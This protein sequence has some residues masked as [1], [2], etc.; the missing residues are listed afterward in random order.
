MASADIGTKKCPCQLK[1]ARAF[2]KGN[3]R[4]LS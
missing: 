3:A 4:L 1:Q 2:I